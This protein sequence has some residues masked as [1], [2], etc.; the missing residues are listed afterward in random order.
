MDCEVAVVGG[1]IGGLTV[2]ALLA[3]RGVNVCLLEREP[4]V[5]GCAASFD[6]FG[7]SFE[8]GD[9]LYTG[10]QSN[11]IHEQVFSELRVDPPEVRL[12]EPRYLVRLPD[13]SEV[14]LTGNTEQFEESLRKTFPECADAAVRFYRKLAPLSE[15]LRRALQRAPDFLSA[16]KSRRAYRLLRDGRIGAEIIRASQ[17]STSEHLDGVS[18]RFR[19]FIDVQLQALA[20]ASSA[21]VAYLHA[22]RIL[23]TPREGMFA[24]RGGA[25]AL[26][27]SL[28][29]SIKRSGG[30][31]R[32]DTPVLR[33]SYDSSGSATGVDLLSGETVTASKAIVSNL[34][35]WDTYGKL[36]GLN[37][38]PSGVRKELKELRSWGA[39]LLYLALD[40]AAAAPLV[41]DH[42]LA[43]TDWDEGQSHNAES[44]QL[45]FAAAPAWDSRGPAVRRAVTVHNFTDVDD[46]FTFHKDETELEEKDQQMLE[47]CWTRLHAIMPE[48]GSSIEVIDTA[49]PR[50]FYDLT[51]R[52]LGMVGGIRSMLKSFWLNVPSYTTSLPNLCIISDTTCAGGI[53]E[54]TRSA[55]VLANKLTG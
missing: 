47:L 7:Y 15:A 24:I 21:E 51:R 29:D 40:E 1:G 54:L 26:A 38:T 4:R 2:A 17:Q 19:R 44:N 6:K 31:I 34:T 28:A 12:L 48:L 25:S 16:S 18:W 13:Q 45:M 36:V 27:E 32:L 14:A 33:L 46:W 10:W 5:G 42:V 30:K 37:R 22:A 53:A 52:K 41:S 3:Q 9:G 11:E 50:T 43:L 20:Q 35:L 23:S 49:T 8:Q 39:Y 55:L